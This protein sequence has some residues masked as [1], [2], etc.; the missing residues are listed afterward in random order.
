MRM[1]T[2]RSA[3]PVP[4]ST[5]RSGARERRTELVPGAQRLG[6]APR[7]RDAAPGRERWIAIED[8]GHGADAV[9]GEVVRERRQ[10][11][12]RRLRVA[13]DLEVSERERTEEPRPDRALV[14]GAVALALIAAVAALVR[15]VAGREA[16]EAVGRDEMPGAGVHDPALAR[17]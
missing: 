5:C 4:H 15:W 3:M 14:V 10:E 12:A 6:D 13:V 1:R 9:I 2:G 17:G 8:L 7:L 16:P 11:R